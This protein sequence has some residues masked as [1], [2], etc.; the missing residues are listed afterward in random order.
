[1]LKKG[2][3]L[4]C[5]IGFIALSVWPSVQGKIEGNVT[6]KAGN[7]LENVEVTITSVQT[8]SRYYKV[9]T[10]KEGKF[11][12][13]GIWPGYYQVTFKKSGLQTVS[14]EVRV[15]ISESTKMDISMERIEKAAEKLLTGADKSFLDGYKLYGEARYE[16]SVR[17]YEEAI[18]L[19]PTQWAYYLNLGLAYKKLDKK[20]ETLSAF[21]KAVELNPESY[22]SQ[23]ELGEALA[24]QEKYGEAKKHYLKATE[25]SPDDPDAF[26][27]LG[28][29]STNLGES[30]EALK[31]YLKTV[32]L[33]EDYAD[34][35]YQIGTIYI[36]Q[37]NPSEAI[38]SLE[39]F[40]EL[41]PEHEKASIANQ[42]LDYLKKN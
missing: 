12:Q 34:A 7:P 33:K 16:E 15:S 38:K 24:K 29:V 32:E 14:V 17:A 20:E 27:N 40:L 22:S 35:Y 6:D 9:K 25:L 5:F 8:A 39:K 41:A 11:T 26:Y 13:I 4:A 28:V 36:G 10:D 2:L 31:A 37:N 42:L 19:N 21:Q 3:L 1:M 18:K 30:D 23:K